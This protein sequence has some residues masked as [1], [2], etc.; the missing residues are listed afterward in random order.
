MWIADGQRISWHQETLP[1]LLTA[2]DWLP[3][4]VSPRN[5]ST[6]VDA[7]NQRKDAEPDNNLLATNAQHPTSNGEA[8]PATPPLLCR[9]VRA[10]T[11]GNCRVAV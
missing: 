1:N 3:S 4:S 2:G 5:P 9:L 10:A 6:P 11:D 7:T 8:E